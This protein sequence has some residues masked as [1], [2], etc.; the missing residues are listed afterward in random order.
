[1]A[2][3][4]GIEK[5]RDEDGVPSPTDEL[6]DWWLDDHRT[7]TT[8]YL[9]ELYEEIERLRALRDVVAAFLEEEWDAPM[10]REAWEAA[11]RGAMREAA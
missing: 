8:S 1:M 4:E 2:G 9:H 5:W 6:R 3:G 10:L 11:S 7:V